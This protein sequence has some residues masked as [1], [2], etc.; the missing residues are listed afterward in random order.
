[1]PSPVQVRFWVRVHVPELVM[2]LPQDDTELDAARMVGINVR[3]TTL[4]ARVRR[5]EIFPLVM[6]PHV[7]SQFSQQSREAA[8][9]PCRSNVKN[10]SI[11]AT[12]G[13]WLMMTIA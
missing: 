11:P 12:P 4:I 9:K 1:M 10:L 2:A 5:M 6:R 8:T 7:P 13:A 3:K